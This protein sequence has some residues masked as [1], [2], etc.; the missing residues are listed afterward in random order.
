M[1]P[2]VARALPSTQTAY[3]S[4]NCHCFSNDN[5]G[6]DDAARTS[7]GEA[8]GTSWLS[9]CF[10]S[11]FKLGLGYTNCLKAERALTVEKVDHKFIGAHRDGGVRDLS[12]E[13]GGEPAV[14]GTVALLFGHHH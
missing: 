6:G 3:I 2:S 9:S 10:S 1:N 4:L 8:V 5:G 12:Y 14:Q 11:S 13:V 7:P